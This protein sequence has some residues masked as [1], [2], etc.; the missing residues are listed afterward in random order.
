MV[1]RTLIYFGCTFHYCRIN[2]QGDLELRLKSGRWRKKSWYR[3]DDGYQY[4]KVKH[5]VTGNQTRVM[6][7]IAVAESFLGRPSS[8]SVACH[9]QGTNRSDSR[10][11]SC[12]FKSVAANRKDRERDGTHSTGRRTGRRLSVSEKHR[13]RTLIVGG[14]SYRSVAE[15]IGCSRQGVKRYRPLISN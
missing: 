15:V 14:W 7:H 1:F 3:A 4:T 13:I 8:S 10:L 12:E 2:A 11:G 6:R 9:G 5:P